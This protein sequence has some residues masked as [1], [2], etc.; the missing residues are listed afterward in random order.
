[1]A[2]VQS[3]FVISDLHIGGDE[4]DPARPNDRGTR[5]CTNVSLLA[6][7]VDALASQPR[8]GQRI[9]LVING[10]VVDFL[11]ERRGTPPRW[12]DFMPNGRQAAQ[13]FER[14][15]D[16]NRSFFHALS[17][18]LDRGHRLVMLL[19]NHDLELSLPDV[20]RALAR[21]LNLNGQHDF[22]FF[23]DGEAYIVADA[24]IEHGNRYDRWNVVDHDKLRELRSWQSRRQPEDLAP[25]F[26]AP[27]GS[28]L[29]CEVINPIRSDYPFIDLLKPENETVL[30]LLLAL[31][32]GYC[33]H[34][35]TAAWLGAMAWPH[36]IAGAARPRMGG[37]IS[38]EGARAY[39][40]SKQAVASANTDVD[41]LTEVLERAMPGQADSFLDILDNDP[42]ANAAR[43]SRGGDIASARERVT[44]GAGLIR[45]LA[46][47]RHNDVER[48]LPALLQAM[49]ALQPAGIFDENRETL[50]EYLE[51]AQSL[52]RADLRY[53]IFGHT[54][55]RRDVRLDSGR[56]Y[57]NSGTWTD[58]I[59]LNSEA[60]AAPNEEALHWLRR[61]VDDMRTG[62]LQQWIK[63][64]STY[65]RLDIEKSGSH[66]GERIA[67]HAVLDFHG[68]AI[69]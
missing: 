29:V 56:Y 19:G 23:Y 24:L 46:A 54:H 18:Y 44:R 45:L 15:V 4:P 17:R 20:R 27:P 26:A 41:P 38:A 35:R 33:A 2:V 28:R 57:L 14:I 1:M 53:V 68:G 69:R 9:E 16:G 65:V 40:R 30:P 5:L 8:S 58:Q 48:R 6:E 61:F 59:R 7:F 12:V 3:T 22:Q 49:R 21:A 25:A 52:A 55:L 43:H 51:S 42:E 64:Q 36:R 34:L 32:P 60:I 50:S 63:P 10:D 39:L 37:D 13:A 31:E 47:T 66:N 67:E 62:S 11:I